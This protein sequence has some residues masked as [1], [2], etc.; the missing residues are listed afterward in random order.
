MYP[1]ILRLLSPVVVIA[2]VTTLVPTHLAAQHSYAVATT[3]LTQP[4]D[5]EARITLNGSV[6]P[7]A[8]RLNDR[9]AA[10]DSMPL[11]RIQLLLKRS[12]TQ[13]SAL[14]QLI[15]DLHNPSSPNYHKWLTPDEFGR[16]F[17]PSDQD[18]ATVQ[19]WLQSH[20][21]SVNKV[22]AGRQTIE[23]SGNVAQF[24]D[25]FHAQIHK[26][27]V[28]G[29]MHYAN[30][31]N[32]QIPTALAPV[33]AGFATLNNFPIKSYAKKLGEA[34]YNVNTGKVTPSWT[35][36]SG[37]SFALSPGDYAVQYDINPLYAAGT[38]GSGQTIAIINESNINVY[39]VNQFRSLFGL[40]NNPPQVIIDGNDPGVDGINNPDGPNYASVEAYLDVE[41]AG[42]VAPNATVDLVIGA[43]T[44]LDSGLFLALQH[45]IFGNIAPVVS[46]SFG[47]CEKV[48]GTT[49]AYLNGLFQ[50][51]AAQGQTVLVSTGDSGSA[52]CDNDNVQYFAVGGQAVNGFASTPYTVSVGGTDFYYSAWNQGSSAIA[53][54]LATYWNTTPSNNKATVSIKGVIPEQPWNE[55]QFGL[56]IF[57]I[58]DDSNGQ[59]TSIAGGGG[60]ASNCATGTYDSNGNT[61]SCTAGYA[62]PSWQTGTGVPNDK[63]RDIPDV[64]LFASSGIN[65]SFYVIC[66]TD[67][68]CQPVSSG[69]TVQIFGVGGT[70]ASAPSFAGLMALVNQKYGRQ[71]QA[72]YVLYP[73]AAQVPTAFHDVTHGT[74]SVPCNITTV[75]SGGT[76]FPPLNCIAAPPPTVNVVDPIYGSATEGQIGTGSTPLYNTTTGFD[77]A[78]GLGTVDA[79]VL[80]SNWNK[81]TFTSSAVTLTSPTAGTYTHGSN[82]T[83]TAKVTGSSPVGNVSLLT[84]NPEVSQQSLGVFSLSSGTATG[85]LNSFPGGTYNV[86]A[87]YGGDGKNAQGQSAKTQITVNPEASGVFLSTLVN[88]S[89]L[90]SGTTGI[91]YGNTFE[92]FAQVAPSS[93][94]AAV[95][96][97]FTGNSACPVYGPPTGVVTFSDGGSAFNTIVLNSYGDADYNAS[98]PVAK[99][100]ATNVGSHSITASYAGDLSYNA[101]SSTA[102]T[103]TIVKADPSVNAASPAPFY[104][105]QATSFTAFVDANG[106]GAPPSGNLTL[107]GFP[108]GTPT[109][110][111]LSLVGIDPVTGSTASYANVTIP[112]SAGAG[113]YNIGVSYP[114]DSNYTSAAATGTIQISAPPSLKPSTTTITGSTSTSP[115]SLANITITVTGQGTLAPTGTIDLQVSGA[116]V[117]SYTL[118]PVSGT[119]TSVVQFAL[120]SS[121]IFQGANILIAAYSGDGNY[122]ASASAPFNIANQLSDFSIVPETAII[123]VP[124]SA[125]ASDILIFSS[126]NGFS[127]NVNLTCTATGGVQCSLSSPYVTLSSGG[128]SPIRLTVTTTGVPA[129]SN[130]NVQVQGVDSSG[131]YI[132][133]IGMRVINAA[134]GPS[135]YL[136]IPVTPCR[137]VDTRLATGP[138]GAPELA[139]G[140]TRSFNIPQSS[141]N[142]PSSAVAYSV[143]ATVLPNAKLNYLTMWPAGTTQPVAST[144]N[145]LDGRIKA[146]A[147]IVPAGTSGAVSVYVSDATQFILDIDGYFVP[148]GTANGLEFYPLTPCR[149][150]DTRQGSGPL[151]GPSLAA[152]ATR[153]FPVLSSSCGIPSTAQA[154]SLNVTAVPSGSLNYVTTWP[155]GSTQPVVSTLNAPTGT[156]VANA[157]IVPAGTSGQIS[158]YASNATNIILDVNGY[159]A[160]PASGGL[161]LYTVTPCRIID[162]RPTAFNGTKVINVE[163][164][165]CAPSST[166]Q[167]YVLNATVVPPG[168]LTYLTLW[169][170]GTTQPVVSTLNA[171]DGAITSNMAIVPTNNGKVDAFVSNTT[172]LILDLSSYFAP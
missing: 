88:G 124:A 100:V 86:W 53:A 89:V 102:F 31:T 85:T 48:L 155:T 123:N 51:A 91:P 71:G 55:S 45:A 49:N 1:K 127:G 163:G 133:A 38:N 36:G 15:G 40:P 65:D 138:F 58:L 20:G 73:L 27:S 105:G 162:T 78:T 117:G 12:D 170:D 129:G 87:S 7:L 64:S 113:N 37:P 61:V 134:A 169:P 99:R 165:T 92:F 83:F 26:Y 77:L 10:P 30:A 96:A 41:W 132:H 115:A 14:K 108:S 93:K 79:N 151:A 157:A 54:Q 2:A 130:Y 95:E 3:R 164:S 121:G 111:P 34:S 153:A 106:L 22:N 109:S 110:V 135:G 69:G 143:N 145:S 60:G 8:N 25:T 17:G 107:S 6:H 13:E 57:S 47:N 149:I 59:A 167:A 137:I 131:H 9:G 159:Y 136:Y 125:T 72:D 150:A 114:G 74:I 142:I 141:C 75:S 5:D 80:V 32:P 63:V 19:A 112:S 166:A 67:G 81:I 68:D 158:I 160:P 28:N 103:Y 16:Q 146:N 147:A 139:A 52:T 116:D 94:L 50:E 23:I 128:Q 44:A 154:Y 43:D 35:T 46:I 33:V 82:I 62:K 70:S 161:S 84:D 97:C 76:S 172:N 98:D 104:Q 101:S 140:S 171:L 18:I 11:D 90:S 122:Q 29:R 24:R 66:A 118:T 168:P 119:D 42:A 39:L 144:L 156:I 120:N 152:G 4:V 126:V 21:F 56:N 148:A